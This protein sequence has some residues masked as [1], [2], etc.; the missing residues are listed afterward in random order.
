MYAY[1]S[2]ALDSYNQNIYCINL[3]INWFTLAAWLQID[4]YCRMGLIVSYIICFVFSN[5]SFKVGKGITTVVNTLFILY[6]LFILSWA[7]FGCLFFFGYLNFHIPNTLPNCTSDL[8]L[9]MFLNLIW[10][11]IFIV[12]YG[13]IYYFIRKI[14]LDS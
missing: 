12:P 5:Q 8:E 10:T 4:A 2:Y 7:I 6:I 3:L 1:N 11:Y 9:Y 13:F 14:L